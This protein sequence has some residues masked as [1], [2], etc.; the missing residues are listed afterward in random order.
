KHNGVWMP[1][2]PS[3]NSADLEQAKIGKRTWL[4]C[5]HCGWYYKL[6]PPPHLAG[7]PVALPSRATV[8]SRTLASAMKAK[9]MTRCSR[10]GMLLINYLDRRCPFCGY[11]IPLP[12]PV[13][14]RVVVRC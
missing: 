14:E 6:S 9:T 8:I 4:W 10:C 1:I 12:A 11:R 3:C 5:S 13:T 7:K 2:C